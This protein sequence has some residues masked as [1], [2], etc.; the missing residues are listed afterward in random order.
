MD[1]EHLPKRETL[2]A[3]R[4]SQPPGVVFINKE[5]IKCRHCSMASGGK[6][7]KNLGGRSPGGGEDSSESDGETEPAKSFHRRLSTN[8][9]IKCSVGVVL[10]VKAR[11]FRAHASHAPIS[12]F[13]TPKLHSFTPLSE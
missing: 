9:D 4:P 6:S 3:R 5:E 13:A 8:R 11:S 2:R 7:A 10:R 1:R 12:R